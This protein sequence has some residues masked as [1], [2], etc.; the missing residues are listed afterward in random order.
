MTD[1]SAGEHII[2]ALEIDGT[3]EVA[4]TPWPSSLEAAS[5]HLPNAAAA[6]PETG[7]IL[8]GWTL[9]GTPF[10][11][12]AAETQARI[13]GDFAKAFAGP[14]A[15]ITRHPSSQRFHDLLPVVAQMAYR[16]DAELAPAGAS[17]WGIDAW[18]VPARGIE[19]RLRKLQAVAR[20]D[21]I[22]QQPRMLMLEVAALGLV[23]KRYYTDDIGDTWAHRYTAEMGATHD[24]KM[25]DYGRDDDPLSNVRASVDWSVPAWVGGMIRLTDK[26]RRL[27]T[28]AI[29]GV[30]QNESALDS[31][32]DLSVYAV[33]NCVLYEEDDATPN[34]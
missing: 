23:A 6:P 20:G 9:N 18:K 29:K 19:M 32:G 17:A 8:R 5:W 22:A 24:K 11:V 14:I 34:R 30:L 1:L 27:Q 2:D 10:E 7:G 12:C 33:I 25:A 28:F 13:K 15:A 4:I 21:A 16:F 31:L 3:K 26:I